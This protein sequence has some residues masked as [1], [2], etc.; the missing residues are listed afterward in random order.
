MTSSLFGEK[1]NSS[2]VTSSPCDEF[3]VSRSYSFDVHIGMSFSL[4]LDALV[5]R[6]MSVK[7]WLIVTYWSASY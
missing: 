2:H 6:Q 5:Q 4:L 7:V 3:T 1:V